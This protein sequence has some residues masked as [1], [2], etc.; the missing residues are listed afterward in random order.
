VFPHPYKGSPL[1]PKRYAKT[2]NEAL[3]R[4][5]IEDRVRPFHDQR[6]SN[7]TNAAAASGNPMALMRLAGHSDFKTTLGYVHL[8]GELFR[9]E[10]ELAEARLYGSSG[11]NR[12]TTDD[13]GMRST[14]PDSAAKSTAT[15]SP[16]PR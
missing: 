10:T 14:S 2:F 1:D 9:S 16:W 4:A 6:H 7:I 8:A 13:A 3:R 15:P 5:G 12:M 11:S